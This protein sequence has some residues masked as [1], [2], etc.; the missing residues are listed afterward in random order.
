MVQKGWN[1]SPKPDESKDGNT[2][3]PTVTSPPLLTGG[4]GTQRRLQ[5][6]ADNT[7]GL[8][9][10][11]KKRIGP[12][13]IVFKNLP[14][15]LAV[16]G[17]WQ[18][19]RLA[20]LPAAKTGVKPSTPARQPNANI[21]A[22]TSHPVVVAASQPVRQAELPPVAPVNRAPTL[23]AVGAL[24]PEIHIHLHG[25]ERQDAREIG[26]IVSKKLNA[27]LARLD[28]MKRGSFRDAD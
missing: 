28:R 26:R 14:R 5:K 7:T 13:D 1:W 20:S 19:S 22:I 16:R 8:L 12:G 18:E 9:D 25:A 11:T 21:A 2:K 3:P 24:P 4:T 23:S 15:A 17:E 27:E 10:E 6:I